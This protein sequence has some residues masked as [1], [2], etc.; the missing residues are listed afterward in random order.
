MW[1]QNAA[2]KL[3]VYDHQYW[4]ATSQANGGG[5]GPLELDSTWVVFPHSGNVY[6]ENKTTNRWVLCVR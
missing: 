4:T 2:T 6:P 5:S 3:N 1:S